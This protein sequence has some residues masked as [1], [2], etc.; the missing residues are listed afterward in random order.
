MARIAGI[1][2]PP[3]RHAEIGLTAMEH[4]KHL[5]MMNVEAD[6]TIGPLLRRMADKAGVC[7]TLV[8]GDQ[9]GCTMQLIEWARENH[10]AVREAR[11]RYVVPEA[12]AAF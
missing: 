9:P 10:D 7:Y 1:N 11:A 2:I 8:D 4:G 5:V 12:Q 3:H 6:V